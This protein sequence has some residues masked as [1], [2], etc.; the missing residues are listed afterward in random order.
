MKRIGT[1]LILLSIVG[2]IFAANVALPEAKSYAINA[3]FQKLNLY[4]ETVALEDVQIAEYHEIERN[5][6]AVYYVF[7]MENYGFIILSA[8]D[9]MNPVQAYSFDTFFYPEEYQDNLTGWWNGRAGAVEYARENKMEASPETQ[10]LWTAIKDPY[11][12]PVLLGDKSVDPLL[13][14]TWN[15]DWPENYYMPLDENGPG[16]R[17]YVGCVATAMSMIMHYWRYPEQGTGTKTHSSGGYPAVTVNYGE[18]TYD[19]DAMMDNSDGAINLPMAEIGLHA[20]VSVSMDWGPNGSGAFSSYVPGAMKYY[21][22]YNSTA[23][24]YE[25]QNYAW[26]S[27]KTYLQGDI[28]A[29]CPIYYAGNNGEAGHAFVMDGYNSDDMYHFNFGWSGSGN[30]WYDITSPSGYDWYYG[31]QMVRYLYPEED[32]YPYG[33]TPDYE[34]NTLVGSFEDGSGPKENYEEDLSCNWLINPQTEFDSVEYVK[35]QFIQLDTDVNDVITIY[36]GATTSDEVLGTYSGNVVPSGFITASGNQM[37]VTFETNGDAVT[38]TGWKAQYYSEQPDYCSSS[39]IELTSETGSL[40]DGSSSFYYKN[41][42]NCMWKIKPDWASGVTL[43]F[44]AFDT[45]ETEDFIQV[46]DASNNQLQ[47]EFSG[48]TIP[49][50]IYVESG[51]LFIIWKTN[52]AITKSG[53]EAS[54]EA[55]NVGIDES[56]NSLENLR[57]FPNPT[58]ESLNITFKSKEYQ[59]FDISLSSLTGETVYQSKTGIISGKYN[60]RINLRSLAKGVYFLN[61]T[62]SEGTVNRKIIVQ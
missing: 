26:S 44:T 19:W 29:T 62:S 38:G 53:W 18:T 2:T 41:N 58:N 50:P 23:T 6:E 49:D 40:E 43:T 56:N 4:H 32:N 7:N 51:E 14:A 60:Q 1:I 9:A 61:I 24:L 57:V 20:A 39:P 15:Q 5:G 11:N 36:D 28:D 31:Q 59:G 47:G 42:S 45:E 21:F 13:T 55:D 27:W 30:G 33:C 46:Y 22:N 37:L 16:G 3:Y 35:L 52:G 17:C 54:W 34:R 10:A 12:A 25:K 8:E 48:S